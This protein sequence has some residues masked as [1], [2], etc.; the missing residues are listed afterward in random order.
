[1]NSSILKNSVSHKYT[2]YKLLKT[3]LFQAIQFSQTV[4][5]ETIPF[6]VSM[7]FVHILL[8]VKIV[9]FQTG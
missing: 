7:V 9:L 8:N 2:V 6:I 1:M 4:L 3:V 5:I